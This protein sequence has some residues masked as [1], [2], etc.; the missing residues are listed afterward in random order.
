MPIVKTLKRVPYVLLR[1][2]ECEY[3]CQ[4]P[5]SDW[6][7]RLVPCPECSCVHMVRM[8]HHRQVE[9][10]RPQRRA[11]IQRCTG[12][13]SVLLANEVASGKCGRCCAK[14]S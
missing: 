13:L 14:M 7:T 5:R 1:C 3:S 6:E 4:A 9:R 11:E 12:C 2:P 8:T 10:R